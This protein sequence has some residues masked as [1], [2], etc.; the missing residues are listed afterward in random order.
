MSLLK[1]K[2]LQD[3]QRLFHKFWKWQ[4]EYLDA[5]M[6]EGIKTVAVDG[7]LDLEGPFEFGNI[8]I[9][10]ILLRIFQQATA[11]IL[12]RALIKLDIRLMVGQCMM[13]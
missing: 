7:H 8:N 13:R 6:M 10:K 1:R 12:Y 3:H 5:F 4:Q 11:A 2:A 9:Q